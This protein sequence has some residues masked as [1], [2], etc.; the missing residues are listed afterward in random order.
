M[1]LSKLYNSPTKRIFMRFL[2]IFVLGGL[3]SLV[4]APEFNQWLNTAL[5]TAVGAAFL[6]FLREVL[7]K[8]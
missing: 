1:L 8:K 7:A 4:F 2:E 3:S 5:G 6:K